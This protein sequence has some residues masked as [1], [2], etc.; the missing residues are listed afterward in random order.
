MDRVI[1]LFRFVDGKRLNSH[2]ECIG[3]N[4]RFYLG[5]D[6]FEA[7]YKKALSKRLLMGRSASVDAEKAMLSKLKNECGSGFTQKLEGMFK[8]ME[9]SKELS[10]AFSV[11][12]TSNYT[13]L[14]QTEFAV[15]VRKFSYARHTSAMRPI[16]YF[17][18]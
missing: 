12:L 15:S 5:K 10:I 17:Y 18:S 6:Y 4:R 11:Y 2:I 1:V 13:K 3:L 9:I 7:F 14:A 8:D 16:R